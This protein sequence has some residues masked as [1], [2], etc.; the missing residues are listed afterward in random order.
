MKKIIGLFALSLAAAALI[1]AEEAHVTIADKP[2]PAS[3]DP[4]HWCW[5]SL[6]YRDNEAKAKSDADVVW[7]GDSITHYFELKENLPLWQKW[8][9]GKEA[10]APYFGL[11]FAIEGDRLR[12]WNAAK[13]HGT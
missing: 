13:R 8:F 6:E 3:E 4:G 5:K 9:G 10:G 2:R 7:L 1:C 11:N 12:T